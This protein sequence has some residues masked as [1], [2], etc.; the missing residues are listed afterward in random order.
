MSFNVSELLSACGRDV[1][2][3]NV[4][5]ITAG[6]ILPL[7]TEQPPSPTRS[8]AWHLDRLMTAIDSKC[9]GLRFDRFGQLSAFAM[10]AHVAPSQSAS[11]LR[12]GTDVLALDDW[13]SGGDTWLLHLAAFRGSLPDL[14][15]QLRD[16][17]LATAPRITFFKYKR[18]R[19]IAKRIDRGDRT[20]FFQRRPN[21]RVADASFLRSREA[22]GLRHAAAD[23]LDT[24]LELG[25]LSALARQC[26][27]LANL[28]LPHAC[29]ACVR[30]SCCRNGASTAGPMARCR[31][32]SPGA[33]STP[34]AHLMR[35]ATRIFGRFIN[36]T[37]ARDSR[38]ATP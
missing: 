38:C 2:V 22:D 27:E 19:R 26:P 20:S 30:P 32:P 16:D 36:G 18:G 29:T 23:M 28:P 14:L 7:M 6:L 9:V 37:R 24:A 1:S 34:P 4:R 17:W 8:L 10:W 13:T 12:L 31:A 15:S 35:P 21:S 25:E 5:F 3:S 11:V 33:G